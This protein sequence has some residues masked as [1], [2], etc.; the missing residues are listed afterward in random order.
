VTDTVNQ[1]STEQTPIAQEQEPVA[2]QQ[3]TETPVSQDN[4]PSNDEQPQAEELTPEQ[5]NWRKFREDR[6]A[7]RK[8]RESDAAAKLASDKAAKDKDD[9]IAALQQ[10]MAQAMNQGQDLTQD[11]QQQIV[12]ELDPTDIPT[13]AQVSSYV[14]NTVQK[15][16][17]KEIEKQQQQIQQKSDQDQLRA[18]PKDNPDFDQVCSTENLDY[19]EFHYPGVA[20]A[21]NNMPDDYTKWSNIY[22][23]VKK[24]VPNYDAGQQK[25]RAEANA[26]KP[27]SMSVSGV[28]ATGDQAPS[29]N[30]DST[31][32][33][34]IWKRMQRKMKGLP[35]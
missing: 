16:L 18:L 20:V 17:R 30:L 29:V 1:D 4:Q 34:E 8:R 23:T 5:I 15:L 26:S 22:K 11:Q 19:L 21:F 35:V 6:G 33:A 9:Q 13:G 12:N 28:S 10:A 7:E 27:Q 3:V 25:A 32:R 14:E 24:L 31:R 2:S